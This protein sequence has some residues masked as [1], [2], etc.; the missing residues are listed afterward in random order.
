MT[1]LTSTLPSVSFPVERATLGNGL[2]VVISQDRR[3]PVIGVA[4]H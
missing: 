3:A 2:R 1:L 4:V